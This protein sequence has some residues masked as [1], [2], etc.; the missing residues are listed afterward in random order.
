MIFIQERDCHM[1]NILN[2]STGISSKSIKINSIIHPLLLHK[3][4]LSLQ[5]FHVPVQRFFN[6]TRMKDGIYRFL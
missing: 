5:S 3:A 4:L 2:Y 6:F 1:G